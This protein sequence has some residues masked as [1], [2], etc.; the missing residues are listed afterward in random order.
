MN[1]IGLS[2]PT[3]R[4]AEILVAGKALGLRTKIVRCFELVMVS[5]LTKTVFEISDRSFIECQA[6]THSDFDS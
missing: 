6:F 2:S 5:D 3:G 1:S 4:R